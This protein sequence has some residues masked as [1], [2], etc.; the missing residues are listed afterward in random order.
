MQKYWCIASAIYGD[1]I[2]LTSMIEMTWISKV[3]HRL[4]L[5]GGLTK[6]PQWLS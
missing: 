3:W 4:S 1:K 5:G 2:I 6:A